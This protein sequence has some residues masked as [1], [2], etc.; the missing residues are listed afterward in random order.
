MCMHLYTV[1]CVAK[2]LKAANTYLCHYVVYKT[3]PCEDLKMCSNVS[4]RINGPIMA[5]SEQLSSCQVQAECRIR[6]VEPWA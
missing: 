5:I 6:W 1:S 3:M 4:S 2:R